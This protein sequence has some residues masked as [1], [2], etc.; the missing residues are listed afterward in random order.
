LPHF[1]G[2]L[3]GQ[4]TGLPMQHA[5]Y[6]G[7]ATT[8]TDLAAGQVPTVITT[9]SDLIGLARSGAVRVIA[10]S[11]ATR[12]PFLPDVP[13]F[14]EG[15]IPIE[16]AGWY[17]MYAKAGTPPGLIDRYNEVAVGALRQPALRERIETL[18]MVPTGTTIAELAAIQKADNAAWA[19][20]VKASGFRPG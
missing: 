18:A 13:T 5:A 2:A 20:A 4:A 9:T 7:S 3:L 14:K 17:A 1:F 16:G 8:M 11:G 10:V 12:S 6:R 15:G 19:P